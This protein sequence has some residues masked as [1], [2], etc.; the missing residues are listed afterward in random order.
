MGG[1]RPED[2]HLYTNVSHCV[3]LVEEDV[4]RLA[5]PLVVGVYFSTPAPLQS[6]GDLL[7]LFG[8]HVRS[9]EGRSRFEVGDL[10]PL[11]R[12]VLDLA[13]A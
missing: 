11:G 9:V 5:D 13:V 12:T 3:P 2:T 6:P 1:V 10:A 4:V 7:D 8:T